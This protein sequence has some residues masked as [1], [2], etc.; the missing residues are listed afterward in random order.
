MI[1]IL[2]QIVCVLG[3]IALSIGFISFIVGMI[4][5]GGFIAFVIQDRDEVKINNEE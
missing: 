3:F 1:T 5:F 4:F 2:I